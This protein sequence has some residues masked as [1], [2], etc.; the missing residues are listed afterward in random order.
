[1]HPRLTKLLAWLVLLAGL[2][3]AYWL[4]QYMADQSQEEARDVARRQVQAAQQ[5]WLRWVYDNPFLVGEPRVSLR[6]TPNY[7]QEWTPKKKQR[8]Y[9]F[10]WRWLASL[11]APV[12]G[13]YIFDVLAADGVRLVLDG[14]VAIDRW[15]GN[16]PRHEL[17]LLRL[18]AGT[19][20]ID[21]QN[22]QMPWRL[23]LTMAWIP[24]GAG[25]RQLIP[26]SNLRPLNPSITPQELAR[27]YR[28]V[29]RWTFL[30]WILP[31]LW[32]LLWLLLLRAPG[33]AW[34]VLTSHRWFLVILGLAGAARMLWAGA[35]HGICGESAFFALRAG[36]ILE[37]ARPFN[38]MNTRVGP[39]WDYLLTLPYAVFGPSWEMLRVSGAVM[40]L[41]A[42]VFCYRVALREAGKATALA[43]T[44]VLALLPALVMYGREPVE[45]TVLGPFFLFLSLDLISL[46]RARPWLSIAAG[47]IWGLSC[48]NHPIFVMVP[49][50]L[51]LSA[52]AISRLRILAW[53]QLWGLGAGLVLGLLPRIYDRVAHAPKDVMS[54]TDP[55]RLAHFWDF[56]WVFG[57]AL[58]GEVIYLGYAGQLLWDTWWVIPLVFAAGLGLLLWGGIW[59]R[60]D[61]WWVEAWLALALAI[62]L[63]MVP[64]GAPTA[65][66]RYFL[67]CLVYAALL[68]G[69]AFAR[70]IEWSS[71]RLKQAMLG[72]LVAFGVFCAASLGINYFYSHLTT[73]G[74]PHQWKSPLLDFTSDAWMNHG[75]LAEELIKRGYPVVAT[76]DFWHHSLHLALNL[77]Q[78]EPLKFQAVA[79][80]NASG[81][82]RA[83]VFYNSPEG[84]ERMNHFLRKHDHHDYRR[85]QLPEHLSSKYILLERTGPP[86][87][88][89][90][91]VD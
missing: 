25:E 1:M 81:T 70:G 12:D 41:L 85:A 90:P 8:P 65:Q 27:L 55:D 69:R 48:F 7:H 42:L 74:L 30:R 58:D 21:L 32:W 61:K 86:V 78:G 23:N 45:T 2:A 47:I 9:P 10:A 54:F 4:G 13:E 18:S 62:H 79:F 63:V 20:L 89:P 88:Y 84:E 83:A 34:R 11:E 59:R 15:V 36:L 75:E 51:V 3:G 64:L 19:H 39:L 44:L 24:P 28:Q 77:W 80:R 31:G 82:E 22:V 17:V 76:G 52:V 33:R 73:G 66:P 91:D 56:Q 67:Y 50:T 57:R 71:G 60:D 5:G 40:S 87:P 26:L 68:L 35:V 46:S 37:G 38:G 16:V 49:F 43:C 72:G 6:P 53:P 14:K 29:Q